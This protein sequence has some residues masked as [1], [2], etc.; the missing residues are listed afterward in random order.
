MYTNLPP[1]N[2]SLLP[3]LD[4][5]SP[6]DVG[7]NPS[8]LEHASENDQANNFLLQ[9]SLRDLRQSE[10]NSEQVFSYPTQQQ[11]YEDRQNRAVEKEKETQEEA[12]KAKAWDLEHPDEV[13]TVSKDAKEDFESKFPAIPEDALKL[14]P[15]SDYDSVSGAGGV[16]YRLFGVDNLDQHLLDFAGG[17]SVLSLDGKDILVEGSNGQTYRK[18]VNVINRQLQFLRFK[19]PELNTLD[20]DAVRKA[21][22]KYTLEFARFV[23][24]FTKTGGTATGELESDFGSLFGSTPFK[25]QRQTKTVDKHGRVVVEYTAKHASG[26]EVTLAQALNAAGLNPGAY[27]SDA[28][29]ARL[30]VQKKGSGYDFK[31]KT[32]NNVFELGV[33]LDTNEYI[34]NSAPDSNLYDVTNS[35]EAFLRTLEQTK[36]NLVAAAAFSLKAAAGVGKAAMRGV[37]NRATDDLTNPKY[38]VPEAVQVEALRQSKILLQLLDTDNKLPLDKLLNKVSGLS[39]EILQDATKFHGPSPEASRVHTVDDAVEYGA[40]TAASATASVTAYLGVGGVKRLTEELGSKG[41]TAVHKY[42][43]KSKAN[44]GSLTQGQVDKFAQGLKRSKKP[45][46]KAFKRDVKIVT[47]AAS[48]GEVYANTIGA[49]KQDTTLTVEQ[50]EKKLAEAHSIKNAATIFAGG[51]V[52]GQL[53]HIFTKAGMKYVLGKGL[54]GVL[55]KSSGKITQAVQGKINK[56]TAD[57]AKR[58]FLLAA[59][60]SV[61]GVTEGTQ[62]LIEEAVKHAVTDQGLD[63]SISHKIIEGM[64][65]GAVGGGALSSTVAI[66]PVASATKA[67]VVAAGRGALALGK[68]ASKKG[69]NN[70]DDNRSIRIPSVSR[71]AVGN[72]I[73]G[74]VHYVKKG[75]HQVD[76][77]AIKKVLDNP[78]EASDA[79][80]DA[81]ISIMGTHYKNPKLFKLSVLGT[82]VQGV[83]DSGKWE[84]VLKNSAD[85]ATRYESALKHQYKR[86]VLDKSKDF[87]NTTLQKSVQVESPID[88]WGTVVDKGIS[89]VNPQHLTELKDLVI[90][91]AVLINPKMGKSVQGLLATLDTYVTPELEAYSAWTQADKKSRGKRPAMVMAN[92]I[93]GLVHDD[94]AQKQKKPII[95]EIIRLLDTGSTVQEETVLQGL[96]KKK[97]LKLAAVQKAIKNNIEY[98]WLNSAGKYEMSNTRPS[99]GISEGYGESQSSVLQLAHKSQK[100]AIVKFLETDIK[101]LKGVSKRLTGVGLEVSTYNKTVVIGERKQDKVIKTTSQNPE[102]VQTSN[103]NPGKI[104]PKPGNTVTVG[105]GPQQDLDG[106]LSAIRIPISRIQSLKRATLV[107]RLE[108]LGLA[109]NTAMTKKSMQEALINRDKGLPERPLEP[110]KPV[111]ALNTERPVYLAFRHKLRRDGWG[112]SLRGSVGKGYFTTGKEVR[113]DNIPVSELRQTLPHINWIGETTG[114]ETDAQEGAYADPE[115]ILEIIAEEFSNPQGGSQDSIIFQEYNRE[116]NNFEIELRAWEK[117]VKNLTNTGS[118]PKIPAPNTSNTSSTLGNTVLMNA[119]A[120]TSK[121]PAEGKTKEYFLRIKAATKKHTNS[122]I[123]QKDGDTPIKQIL[124]KYSNSSELA[125]RELEILAEYLQAY[126]KTFNTEYELNAAYELMHVLDKESKTHRTP[127]SAEG[128]QESSDSIRFTNDLDTKTIDTARNTAIQAM[129]NIESAESVLLSLKD[130]LPILHTPVFSFGVQLQTYLE[131][132]PS[133]L[134]S[135]DIA[136]AM[137]PQ[138]KTMVQTLV[139]Q[140]S[141]KSFLGVFPEPDSRNQYTEDNVEITTNLITEAYTNVL[142]RAKKE[143]MDGTTNYLNTF[144]KTPLA[145]FKPTRVQVSPKQF[146]DIPHPILIVVSAIASGDYIAKNMRDPVRFNNR[147]SSKLARFKEKDGEASSTALQGLGEDINNILADMGSEIH[148][149]LGIPRIDYLA[150]MG[151]KVENDRYTRDNMLQPLED[152]ISV[153][154][155]EILTDTLGNNRNTPNHN[156]KKTSPSYGFAR[157]VA[158]KV[159]R[160][161]TGSSTIYHLL[162]MQNFRT[163][164]DSS[165]FPATR[166]D[167][168]NPNIPQIVHQIR[169]FQKDS[170]KGLPNSLKSP[171]ALPAMH[172]TKELLGFGSKLQLAPTHHSKELEGKSGIY[173]TDTGKL[174]SRAYKAAPEE[175]T[176]LLMIQA[177]MPATEK[178]LLHNISQAS[179]YEKS[180]AAAQYKDHQDNAAQ[181]LDLLK[182]FDLY[183]PIVDQK[184]EEVRIRRL[185]QIDE[186]I[187]VLSMFIQNG[188]EQQHSTLKEEQ[189]QYQGKLLES[190]GTKAVSSTDPVLISQEASNT[191]R[192]DIEQWGKTKSEL[193]EKR[194]AFQSAKAFEEHG[195]KKPMAFY[196]AGSLGAHGRVVNFYSNNKVLRSLF[197]GSAKS[198]VIVLP[199][200]G[201]TEA[202]SQEQLRIN[203]RAVAAL[204]QSLGYS[205]DKHGHMEVAQFVQEIVT[206]PEVLE[207]SKQINVIATSTSAKAIKKASSRIVEGYKNIVAQQTAGTTEI[208]IGRY[209]FEAFRT[210]GAINHQLSEALDK[211]SKQHP[212]TKKQSTVSIPTSLRLEGDGITNSSFLTLFSNYNKVPEEVKTEEMLEVLSRLG[213]VPQ[214]KEYGEMYAKGLQDTYTAMGLWSFTYYNESLQAELNK[215]KDKQKPRPLKMLV[216]AGLVK[217]LTMQG[218]SV[219]AVEGKDTNYRSFIK[220]ISMTL[221]YMAG[222][223]SSIEEAAK[224]ILENLIPANNQQGTKGV[225]NNPYISS[226][227]EA[228][229]AFYDRTTK[230]ADTSEVKAEIQEFLLGQISIENPKYVRI[231]NILHKTTLKF[232]GEDFYESSIKGAAHIDMMNTQEARVDVYHGAFLA[233]MYHSVLL[234]R[235]LTAIKPLDTQVQA[236]VLDILATASPKFIRGTQQSPTNVDVGT[237]A[238][239][240]SPSARVLQGNSI[241]SLNTPK[242]VLQS[243]H[244]EAAKNHNRSTNI[245]YID[246]SGEMVVGRHQPTAYTR[247]EST[248]FAYAGI[249]TN[250]IIALDAQVMYEM[251]DLGFSEFINAYDAFIAPIDNV[252]STLQEAN[253]IVTERALEVNSSQEVADMFSSLDLALKE[254]SKIDP[255]LQK[256]EE[257]SSELGSKGLTLSEEFTYAVRNTILKSRNQKGKNFQHKY[258][259]LKGS[260]QD[261]S[262][263]VSDL[264]KFLHSPMFY[265][266]LGV[267]HI[268][269]TGSLG[270]IPK[271]LDLNTLQEKFQQESKKRLEAVDHLKKFI[272]ANN[273]KVTQYY[274]SDTLQNVSDDDLASNSDILLGAANNINKPGSFGSSKL[275]SELELEMDAIL[276]HSKPLTSVYAS[277]VDNYKKTASAQELELLQP[278]DQTVKELL[279]ANNLD[280]DLGVG[281]TP[282]VPKGRYQSITDRRDETVVLLESTEAQKMRTN[283]EASEY[284]VLMHELGHALYNPLLDRFPKFRSLVGAT[285]DA[286]KAEINALPKEI[287]GF[288]LFM[289][290][291]EGMSSIEIA[292]ETAVAKDIY[293]NVFSATTHNYAEFLVNVTTNPVFIANLQSANI[294]IDSSVLDTVP[295]ALQIKV[296]GKTLFKRLMQIITNILLKVA[297]ALHL[298]EIAGVRDVINKSNASKVDVADF[299]KRISPKLNSAIRK[300]KDKQAKYRNQTLLNTSLGQFAEK[301]I[302]KNR[303]KLIT[304]SSQVI[305][306]KFK[307]LQQESLRN[308]DV[309]TEGMYTR[310]LEQAVFTSDFGKVFEKTSVAAKAIKA[311][312]TVSVL[313]AHKRYNVLTKGLIQHLEEHKNGG[314]RFLAQIARQVKDGN[315]DNAKAAQLN[316]V[317]SNLDGSIESAKQGLTLV[318]SEMF[319]ISE[320]SKD[321]KWEEINEQLN[322]VVNSASLADLFLTPPEDSS[323]TALKLSAEDLQGT[324][325]QE[326][327]NTVLGSDAAL[328]TEALEHI[329]KFTQKFSYAQPEHKEYFFER[330]VEELE[331]VS[332]M[333][334]FNTTSR[335]AGADSINSAVYRATGFMYRASYWKSSLIDV[336]SI[337]DLPLVLV[338]QHAH[339][340]YL[341]RRGLTLLSLSKVSSVDRTSAI[342]TLTSSKTLSE[343]GYKNMG[344][345]KHILLIV[346]SQVEAF[347]DQYKT[348][349]LN[350]REGHSTYPKNSE[351]T[352]IIGRVSDAE[353]LGEKG[354]LPVDDHSILDPEVL[355][356]DPSKP[357]YDENGYTVYYSKSQY[358]SERLLGIFSLAGTSVQGVKVSHLAYVGEAEELSKVKNIGGKTSYGKIDFSVKAFNDVETET[359]SVAL[360]YNLVSTPKHDILSSE[361]T[362]TPIYASKSDSDTAM[363]RPWDYKV[364]LSAAL[365]KKIFKVEY[366]FFE[367][368]VAAEDKLGRLKVLDSEVLQSFIGELGR[369]S[370]KIITDNPDNHEYVAESINFVDILAENNSVNL[371]ELPTSIRQKLNKHATVIEA[372]IAEGTEEKTIFYVHKDFIL[373]IFGYEKNSLVNYR[374]DSNNWLA[375]AL[376]K[377]EVVGLTDYKI[378]SVEKWL[379]YVTVSLKKTVLYRIPVVPVINAVSMIISTVLLSGSMPR[380]SAMIAAVKLDLNSDIE[381]S[382]AILAEETDLSTY[383]PDSPEYVKSARRLAELRTRYDNSIMRNYESLGLV[384]SIKNISEQALNQTSKE[385][386]AVKAL[387]KFVSKSPDFLKKTLK[388]TLFLEGSVGYSTTFALNSRVDYIG[389]I[390]VYRMYVENGMSSEQARVLAMDSFIDYNKALSKNLEYLERV[391][392]TMF[393]KFTLR[394]FRAAYTLGKT[395]PLNTALWLALEATTDVDLEDSIDA[396]GMPGDTASS[397]PSVVN[398][399]LLPLL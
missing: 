141:I 21:Y 271:A 334:I 17:N 387:G 80:V 293:D 44:K 27:Y 312:E 61:E 155:L 200:P 221:G 369:E 102:R 99:T 304:A 388:E 309:W 79:D 46:G 359:H 216:Q 340:E 177:E 251:R 232:I 381:T 77:Q 170:W 100:E 210:I 15:G 202:L 158:R 189:A 1:D 311:A 164:Q 90:G 250:S 242:G 122:L 135:K 91:R 107:N 94:N 16:K 338:M 117:T 366:N 89:K 341:L 367:Q 266:E 5:T 358:N 273:L 356:I 188:L 22:K 263:L 280:I 136:K 197:G 146:K 308:G 265:A 321:P 398:A 344:A 162:Q 8:V 69:I 289:A 394:N 48:V 186:D 288:S 331:S 192:K 19:D 305:Q 382:V 328:R 302:S 104:K 327:L 103:Y 243:L 245:A 392:I 277:V 86:T 372:N 278:L 85:I 156:N 333:A 241:D 149:I 373:N 299:Y 31:G 105:Y 56:V 36:G 173:K 39:E 284:G 148:K 370:S 253:K 213:V 196:S 163:V 88:S 130:V 219:V 234:R 383:V 169:K 300:H 298:E 145:L 390:A 397:L 35:R 252:S 396:L 249:V 226:Y 212:D 10:Q 64:F 28:E 124:K 3:V 238:D 314:V 262:V 93:Y 161:S 11:E 225:P 151:I 292:K 261:K 259:T 272:Q 128:L 230:D 76:I 138:V 12:V 95:Q 41:I 129:P 291:T 357:G 322:T 399:G 30:G 319:D 57:I 112:Q 171:V 152:A 82:Y 110:V 127:K 355:R 123:E 96:Q 335:V 81:V 9:Q 26:R 203:N 227:I 240:N 53:E 384:N 211:A 142:Q 160:D 59:G 153:L 329:L 71:D 276:N 339:N 23:S 147:A 352:T 137:Y 139:A 199:I 296:D 101:V 32:L 176:Q 18:S 159:I 324:R 132:N 144:S 74:E 45:L 195:Y 58:V 84:E 175:M 318:L 191:L 228:L 345:L 379:E 165:G 264:D 205:T 125:P 50:V 269:T 198:A 346:S 257:A 294:T 281:S 201:S 297:G 343:K 307:E 65:A 285:Y 306:D 42:I 168:N 380:A 303:A 290:D 360:G 301:Y 38:G 217:G 72:T 282:A 133:I 184:R 120:Q 351:V 363:F 113:I 330:L 275:D 353:I 371:E 207:I 218:D 395:R 246:T 316:V 183:E 185:Q 244:K 260:Q 378:Q 34:G 49:I 365:K 215:P 194:K 29:L 131:E 60:A 97:E 349:P 231:K 154:G 362:L 248:T 108:A 134:Q 174:V 377:A 126:S 323:A 114:V 267:D 51:W 315:L 68:A 7:E 98:V 326:Q 73:P 119:L 111:E 256:L 239:I 347:Y 393:I 214:D 279:K 187:E 106:T 325:V 67:L 55:Q 206:D 342:N 237:I 317:S 223:Q 47:I 83:K 166:I 258:V 13:S 274:G 109:T 313:K 52:H 33:F 389:K 140:E 20:P 143:N 37:I 350:F 209:S 118:P 14:P 295:S 236:R 268:L 255:Q 193:T 254:I 235:T 204:A 361:L 180:K 286:V 172:L 40:S 374:R 270:A 368:V 208:E 386:S 233:Y 332:D 348:K 354:F 63:A 167:Q 224:A 220:Y 247:Q 190:K 87:F 150:R 2:P 229:L 116:M 24:N 376:Q 43:L 92:T 337:R 70:S 375:N 336:A 78:E 157:L 4:E 54:T 391:G 25:I 283:T 179:P 181:G 66:K 121:L 182:V 75:N 62:V 222:K 320:I 364:N 385:I 115:Q 310:M 178:D 6:R 287:P